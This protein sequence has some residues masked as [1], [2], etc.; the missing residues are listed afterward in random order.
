MRLVEG[1]ADETRRV[2]P[3]ARGFLDAGYPAADPVA[4]V[5]ASG[6]VVGIVRERLEPRLSAPA[7]P[8]LDHC[9]L[10]YCIWAIKA[11]QLSR[12]SEALAPWQIRITLP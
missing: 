4:G 7:Q 3:I 5:K 9:G 1:L 6:A 11:S 12:P 2:V 8:H 10:H